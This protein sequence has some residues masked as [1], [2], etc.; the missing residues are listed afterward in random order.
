MEKR[1]VFSTELHAKCSSSH[2]GKKVD[3]WLQMSCMA[4]S[5]SKFF[6]SRERSLRSLKVFLALDGAQCRLE[7]YLTWCFC[8]CFVM[9]IL[10]PCS[11]PD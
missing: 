1:F 9:R 3:L 6:D 5:G 8:Q 7:A 4:L 2:V 11:Y 10:L